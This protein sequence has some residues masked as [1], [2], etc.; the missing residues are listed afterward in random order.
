MRKLSRILPIIAVIVLLLGVVSVG[1]AQTPEDPVLVANTGQAAGPDLATATDRAAYAQSF[2]TGS[3]PDGYFLSS[4]DVGLAAGSGVTAEVAL[5]WSNRWELAPDGGYRNYPLRKLT[6]LSAPSIDNDASTL[7][8]FST[9]DVLLLPDTTYW[10][11]V[12]RTGGADAGLSVGATSSGDAVDAGGM[13]GFSVGNNVWVPGTPTSTSPLAPRWADYTS[14]VDATMKIGL[15]GTEATRP[16]GPYATN[17]NEYTYAAAAETSSS[18][19]RYATSFGTSFAPSASE[20]TSVVLSVA[21]ESGVTPRVAIHADSSGS[22]AASAVTN[23]T[24]TAPTDLSRVLGAPGRA[25]FTTSTA[26]SLAANTVY[27]VV[28]DVGSGSGKLSVSTTESNFNDGASAGTWIIAYTMKA[29]NGSSWSSD[30]DGRSFRMALNGRTDQDA[31]Y[32]NSRRVLIGLPQVGVEVAAEIYEPCECGRIKNALWQWQRGETSDGTFTDIP[33]DEGGTSSG[34]LPAAADLGKWLKALVTYENAFGPNKS[35]S[36]VSA[37][38]VL[39]QPIIS[40]AGQIGDLNYELR[41][42]RTSGIVRVAQAFTT[43][44]NSSGYSLKALRF[45]IGLDAEVSALSW[46]LYADNAGEPAAAP[47]FSEVPV[48]ADNV[49]VDPYTFEELSHPGLSLEPD[50][51]YWAVLTSS[52]LTEGTSASII[53]RGISEWGDHVILDGPAAELDPGSEP[54]WTID[55]PPPALTATEPREWGPYISALELEGKIV[56]LMSVLTYPEVTATFEQASYTVAEGATQS[57]TVTLS[58][59]PERTVTVPI[60]ATPQDGAA[61]ADYSVPASVTFD[62]GETSKSITFTAAQDTRDDEGESVLLSFGDLPGAVLAGASTETTLSITDDDV[63]EVNFG[64]STYAVSEGGT[65]SVEVTLTSA[66]TSAVTVPITATP[67]GD[68]T[69]ADYSVPS[70]VT[71]DAGE[72]SKAFTFTGATDAVEDDGESVLLALGTLPG[73]VQT[74]T[75]NEATVS[76][77]ET[78]PGCQ[79]GDLWCANVVYSGSA[80]SNATKPSGRKLLVWG[81]GGGDMFQFA[82]K[83]NTYE[84]LS[85]TLGPNPGGGTYVR[86]PFHIPERSKALLS[87]FHHRPEERQT[88]WDVPNK[89]YLDW[90]LYISTG[91]GD[92]FVEARLPLN[93]AKFCCGHLWRW[94]GHDLYHLNDAWTATKEYRLRIVRDLSADRTPEVLGPP[95]HLRTPGATRHNALVHWVR[96]QMR[97]DAAPPGVS[98]KVQWKKFGHNWDWPPAVSQ[99]DYQP[100]AGKESLSRLISGLT[101]NTFYDVRV[102]AVNDDGDSAPSNVLRFRTD[103]IPPRSQNQAAN[104]PATGGPG[105]TGTVR[106]GETLTATT[107]GIEDED[108]LTGAVFSYQWVRQDLATFDDTDIEGATGSTYTVTDDD[109]GK[110]I[111]VRVTFTDDAGNEESLTSYAR[112]SAPLLVIPDEEETPESSEAR[113][114]EGEQETPLTATIHDAPES[115]DG[116]EDFS[117]ELRFSEDPK[118]G[119]SYV[120]LKDHAFTVTGGE[121]DGARRLE[122]GKNIRWEIRVEPVSSGDVTVVLPAT[123]D[124]EADG[125]VCTDDGRMLSGGLEITVSGPGSRQQAANTPATG[126]PAISGTARVGET[127]TADTSGIADEDGLTNVSYSYQWVSDDTDIDGATDSSYTLSADDVG[128]TINVRVS[129]EDDAGNEESVTSAATATAAARPS[130]TA[131]VLNAPQSHNGSD[132][133]TFELRFSEEPKEDF[134]YKTLKDHAFTVTGGEVDGARRLVSGSNIRWEITVTPDSSGD[135]TVKLPVTKDCDADGAI[136]TEDGRMLSEPLEITV[137]GPGQ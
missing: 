55:F 27:W 4:V 54:D 115:H 3:N 131:S 36:G 49:E 16:P 19:S 67:Q 95:L 110:A 134:S 122:E 102:I 39:S 101:A 113:E 90:T 105:I 14:S 65:V 28:L 63:P 20:L 94:H 45:G 12:T 85:G 69:T 7:E 123:T 80:A 103:T 112:L 2:T 18:I 56:V 22:P 68:T 127:L 77:H 6:T 118:T 9:S 70:G 64:D 58:A 59:D 133:F 53:L 96:P 128:K 21:A 23:G 33:A 31:S 114:A 119:F 51:K 116:Q 46:A 8:R 99:Q 120:T 79:A 26:I 61:A 125:A 93:E 87:V 107:D 108:G 13:A 132:D 15:R 71:F 82:Y 48:P 50:T 88:R 92:D 73:T 124:C 74:G 75:V 91:T 57:V 121:V 72:T 42:E 30:S 86:P 89:D 130:L 98:Y 126:E 60:E 29:Y 25:E 111:K 117:F 34:Y 62:A 76:I 40:N 10:I 44:E 106:A 52:P 135:V 129:F 109:E 136:C 37:N 66:L 83:G 137:N 24:L 17:R 1:H 78:A 43:G 100:P 41:T 47:L 11:A 38:P 5:W 35:V 32:F 97:N 84:V 104:S 81:S